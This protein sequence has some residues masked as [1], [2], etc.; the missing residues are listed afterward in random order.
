ML[1]AAQLQ[2]PNDTQQINPT[3]DPH[4]AGPTTYRTTMRAATTTP[5]TTTC[6]LSNTPPPRQTWLA[7]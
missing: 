7:A 4:I 6:A 1:A 2:A 3:I 5:T